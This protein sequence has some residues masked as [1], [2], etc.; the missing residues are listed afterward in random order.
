MTPIISTT[1]PARHPG[2]R[3]SEYDPAFC[4]QLVTY[5]DTADYEKDRSVTTETVS[6]DATKSVRKTEVRSGCGTFPSFEQ[7]AGSIGVTTQTLRNWA[8]DYPDF[9]EAYARAKDRQKD[10]LMQNATSGLINAQWAI[11]LATNVTDMT[12]KHV[13]ESQESTIDLR[14]KTPEQ[15][16]EIK[17]LI[18]RARQIAAAPG[19]RT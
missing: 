18:E 4:D 15:L 9:S 5:F 11:F 13:V 17:A 19:G 16:A 1:K 3:P 10:W 8:R 14:D 6:G 7:F 2:G 12:D